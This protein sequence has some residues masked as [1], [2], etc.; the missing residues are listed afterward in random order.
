MVEEETRL[1]TELASDGSLYEGYPQRIRGLHLNQANALEMIA[2]THGWPKIS[3]VGKEGAD[4][5]W[6]IL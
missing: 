4:A 3:L 2:A 5:S 1:K 6:L